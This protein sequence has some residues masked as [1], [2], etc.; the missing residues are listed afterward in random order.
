VSAGRRSA[1]PVCESALTEQPH[2]E[3][4]KLKLQALADAAKIVRKELAGT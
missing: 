4:V 2:V 3:V 1:L